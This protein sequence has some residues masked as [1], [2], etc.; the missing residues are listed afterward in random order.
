M[1]PDQ[2]E[3]LAI[4]R[5]DQIVEAAIR[6]WLADG[7]DATTVSAIA[8]EAELAK[9]TLYLY[10][11]AKQDIL[12]EAINRYSMLPDLRGFLAAARDT[13][14]TATIPVLVRAFWSGLRAR[15]DTIRFF[16]REV[17]VRPEHARHFVQTVVLPSN[18]AL[19][20]H[21]AAEID[22]GA[23]RPIN[24]FI[25]ARAL[26]GMLMIF[27]FTQEIFDGKSLSPL[28]DD[29]IVDTIADLFLFGVVAREG[30]GDVAKQ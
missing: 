29:E 6:C 7:Y 24:M 4:S 28:D 10:F 18:A 1:A 21:F 30:G 2:R 17:T 22:T 3:A 27:L 12:D 25:A 5:R 16:V 19:A 13:P 11:P 20:A 14:I 26:V 23:L 15:T 9:G 8:R